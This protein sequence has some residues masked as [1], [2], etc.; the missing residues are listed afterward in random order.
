MYII[1]NSTYDCSQ[2][3]C[4]VY[5]SFYSALFLNIFFCK[6]IKLAYYVDYSFIQFSLDCAVSF[7]YVICYIDKNVSDISSR[8][9][10]D[11]YCYNYCAVSGYFRSIYK[12]NC[13]RFCLLY[14]WYF[15]W[16][17]NFTFFLFLFVYSGCY[18]TCSI[19]KILYS[20]LTFHC[21]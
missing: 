9:Y 8:N 7:S 5:V 15:H 18:S 2:V 3:V 20:K 6:K 13:F 14:C 12:C 10:Y 11:Y 17:Y 21:R 16:N 1:R 4:W 19:K